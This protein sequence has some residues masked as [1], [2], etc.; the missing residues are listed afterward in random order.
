MKSLRKHATAL[1]LGAVSTLMVFSAHGGSGEEAMAS[2]L[3]QYQTAGSSTQWQNVWMPEASGMAFAADHSGDSQMG[4]VI[5]SHTRAFLDKGAWENTLMRNS[6]YAAP[7][8][9]LATAVGSGVTSPEDGRIEF[10]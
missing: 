5:A 10:L 3:H 6:Q 8:P 4:K 7:N 9:L 1:V 2:A